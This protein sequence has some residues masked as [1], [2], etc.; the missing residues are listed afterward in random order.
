MNEWVQCLVIPHYNGTLCT[1]IQKEFAM[2]IT[3]SFYCEDCTKQ[4]FT[5]GEPTVD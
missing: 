4:I 5:I 1:I 2:R 3:A